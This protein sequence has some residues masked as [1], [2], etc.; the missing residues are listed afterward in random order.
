MNKEACAEIILNNPA[1][2][3]LQIGYWND[4]NCGK[5]NYDV[6]CRK[7]IDYFNSY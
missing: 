5:L 7:M 4:I 2:T 1:G 6:C 3:N